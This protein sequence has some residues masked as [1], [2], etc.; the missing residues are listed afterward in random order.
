M[1][2]IR[3]KWLEQV[4]WFRRCFRWGG[5]VAESQVEM[6][7]LERDARTAR[8]EATTF[9]AQL[10]ATEEMTRQ[11]RHELK[12]SKAGNRTLLH[13]VAQTQRLNVP[14]EPGSAREVLT[15]GANGV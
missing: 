12:Q 11:L 1:G 8:Q 10:T 9:H 15:R 4:S 14:V 2:E 13:F 7:S 6:A 3:M 5:V